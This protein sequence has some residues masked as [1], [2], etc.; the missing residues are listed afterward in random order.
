M[1]ALSTIARSALQRFGFGR[2]RSLAV[3]GGVAAGAARLFGGGGGGDKGP[4]RRRR[5]RILTSGDRSDIAFV[6]ATLGSPAGKSF[7]LIIAARA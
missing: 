1:L 4:R 7:A 5:K 3:S 6:V 2:A